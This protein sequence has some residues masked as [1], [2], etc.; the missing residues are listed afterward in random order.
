MLSLKKKEL[1]LLDEEV[2]E[3]IEKFAEG[4][5]QDVDKVKEY[6]TAQG[7][8]DVIQEEIKMRKPLTCLLPRLL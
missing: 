7:Q 5:Q 1:K 6:F 4:I 3:R 8:G 2:E